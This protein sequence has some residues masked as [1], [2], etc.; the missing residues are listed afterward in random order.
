M[1]SNTKYSSFFIDHGGLVELL[2]KYISN[3]IGH[4]YA[5]WTFIMIG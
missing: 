3:M 4:S 2:D 1:Y 5:V